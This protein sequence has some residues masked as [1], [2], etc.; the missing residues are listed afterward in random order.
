MGSKSKIEWTDATWNPTTG[1]TKVSSGC[2]FCYAE[3]LAEDLQLKGARNYRNG[4]KL[5]THEHMLET[6]LKWKKPKRVFVNSMSDLFHEDIPDEFIHRV[7]DV[8]S[9]AYWHQFQVLT[10]RIHRVVGMNDSLNWAPNIWMGVSIEDDIVQHRMDDL[11]DTD[12][13]VKFL[14]IEPLI[15][16]LTPIWLDDIDWVIVGGESGKT[17]R[18]MKPQWAREI[19]DAC[20]LQRV[21]FFFK[22]WGGVNKRNAGRELDGRTWDE[23]P[24]A[25]EKNDLQLNL[26][27]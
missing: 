16:Q 9:K 3:P 6:P 5:T 25:A 21:P 10:K 1:C 19:R 17:P 24:K 14:S 22:Q 8:M 18:P 27:M 4:F 23:F 2:K 7:F 20:V 13:K 15:G 12:A 26:V 11:R